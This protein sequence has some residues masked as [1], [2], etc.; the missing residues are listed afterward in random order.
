VPGEVALVYGDELM[1]HHL[2]D[3]HP[4]Q[5]IRVKLAMDLI[6]STG[7]IEHAHLLPPRAATTAELGLVH[8]AE[9]VELVRMLSDPARLDP[10]LAGR[11]VYVIIWTTTPWTLPASMAVAFHPDFEYVAAA[12]SEDAADVYLLEARRLEPALAETGLEAR[13]VLARI[14][15]RKLERVKFQH[16]FLCAPDA[17][18]L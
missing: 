8:S 9:Y 12:Q 1:K 4:L 3:Q 7:L 16:P 11:Q 6:R 14:P 13:T 17:R 2:S 18:D 10:A 15:G 5:P